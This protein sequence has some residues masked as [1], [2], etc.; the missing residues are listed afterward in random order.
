M[1]VCFKS[2]CKDKALPVKGLCYLSQNVLYLFT[3]RLCAHT[4]NDESDYVKFSLHIPMA[5]HRSAFGRWWRSVPG[6]RIP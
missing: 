4:E 2:P 1:C 5:R 6:W 3:R